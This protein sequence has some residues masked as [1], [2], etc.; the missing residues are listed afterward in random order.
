MQN[1]YK[2]KSGFPDTR[3]TFNCC[4]C[5]TLVWICEFKNEV[6][7]PR[8]EKRLRAADQKKNNHMG[9][10]CGKTEKKNVHCLCSSCMFNG[11]VKK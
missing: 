3:M 1:I 5:S 8:N 11:F 9:F 2:K 7:K 6:K 4:I 10:E